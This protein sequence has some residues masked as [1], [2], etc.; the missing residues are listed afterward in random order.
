MFT[1]LASYLRGA[2][3]SEALRALYYA[4]KKHRGT[5]TEGW[6]A[7]Y[8]TSPAYGM[9]CGGTGYSEFS[10]ILYI[11]RT[12]LKFIAGIYM[13]VF[14]DQYKKW[15]AIFSASFVENN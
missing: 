15:K 7:L 13:M 5:E 8:R 2:G 4:R 11:I 14:N 6:D 10:D 3:M 12:N 9:L 1:S